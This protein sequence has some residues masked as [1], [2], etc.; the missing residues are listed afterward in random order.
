MPTLD[1]NN[2]TKINS[3]TRQTDGSYSITVDGQIS[4][5][6]LDKLLETARHFLDAQYKSGNIR[7]EEYAQASVTLYQASLQSAIQLFL[8]LDLVNSQL[9]SEQKK[10]DLLDRQKE[11][12]D[13]DFLIK[14][15]SQ[16]NNGYNTFLTTTPN[17]ENQPYPSLFTK[18]YKLNFANE[19]TN[20]GEVDSE[21]NPITYPKKLTEID[22]T[23]GLLIERIKRHGKTDIPPETTK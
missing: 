14:A 17:V 2:L 9:I 1:L 11:G 20:S 21:G 13:D 23:M 7:K 6:I 22:G 5:A 10:Q 12:Y 15:I 16:I 19:S 3:I 8:Q 4:D 18:F